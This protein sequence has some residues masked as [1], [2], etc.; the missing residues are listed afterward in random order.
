M[1]TPERNNEH[2]INNKEIPSKENITTAEQSGVER[3]TH[4]FG[5]AFRDELRRETAETLSPHP[6][7]SEENFQKRKQMVLQAEL[8]HPVIELIPEGQKKHPL[9]YFSLYDKSKKSTYTLRD[10]KGIP[11]ISKIWN[12]FAKAKEISPLGAEQFLEQSKKVALKPFEEKITQLNQEMLDIKKEAR[13]NYKNKHKLISTHGEMN[14]TEYKLKN[15]KQDLYKVNKFLETFL[16]PNEEKPQSTLEEKVSRVQTTKEYKVPLPTPEVTREKEKTN[17]EKFE[18]ALIEKLR[19]ITLESYRSGVHPN[20]KDL[21]SHKEY[22]ERAQRVMPSFVFDK[23]GNIKEINFV[24]GYHEHDMPPEF[25]T[26]EFAPK[27][28]NGNIDHRAIQQAFLEASTKEPKGAREFLAHSA[29]YYETGLLRSIPELERD[30]EQH[31]H[32]LRAQKS[33]TMQQKI[34]ESL[35]FREQ[36]LANA[37]K[38]LLGLSK[39]ITRLETNAPQT[40]ESMDAHQ[41]E[42]VKKY[43]DQTET[44]I[45]EPQESQSLTSETTP[46]IEQENESSPNIS[47]SH[48]LPEKLKKVIANSARLL[49]AGGVGFAKGLEYATKIVLGAGALITAG[50]AWYTFKYIIKIFKASWKFITGQEIKTGK[51]DN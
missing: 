40:S 49:A 15:A 30:I 51:K 26:K 21:A 22:I 37:K 2:E 24:I 42:F 5:L 19:A 28:I 18:H 25:I 4:A 31:Q 41:K 33:K 46:I 50:V 43:I 34:K 13:Q 23:E 29:R 9:F 39:L 27:D 12:A 44:K 20:S 32:I 8:I 35:A 10:T 45:K 17:A 3:E 11:L 14:F 47:S 38:E 7:E 16:P 48:E 6:N 1:K 36:W